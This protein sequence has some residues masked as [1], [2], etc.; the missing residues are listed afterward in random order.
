MERVINE[1]KWGV[2]LKHRGS[3]VT[4]HCGMRIGVDID[5]G[6]PLPLQ[7]VNSM[8][9]RAFFMGGNGMVLL[10]CRAEKFL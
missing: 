7:K 1:S 8:G 4:V 3:S 5:S 2:A 10:A 6:P 9:K